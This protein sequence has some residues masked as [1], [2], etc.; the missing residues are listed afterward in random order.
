MKIFR[1]YILLS[2]ISLSFSQLS[3]TIDKN[4]Y[5]SLIVPGWGQL[6]L[7]EKNRSRNFFI[8]EALSLIHI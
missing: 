1:L 4:A 7:D 6:E 2:L 8:L 5:K 3:Q